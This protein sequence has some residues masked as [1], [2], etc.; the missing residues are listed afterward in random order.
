MENI[1]QLISQLEAAH[2]NISD[3]ARKL[4]LQILEMENQ[5]QRYDFIEREVRDRTLNDKN[6]RLRT[7]IIS[8]YRRMISHELG[9]VQETEQTRFE[10]I[11]RNAQMQMEG[12]LAYFYQCQYGE[13]VQQFVT[14]YNNYVAELNSNGR[15]FHPIQRE[16]WDK[17]TF[18][19]K[20][21]LFQHVTQ[22]ASLINF[23]KLLNRYRNSISHSGYEHRAN[24][25]AP[26]DDV[27]V[28]AR[29]KDVNAVLDALEKL[30]EYVEYNTI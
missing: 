14:A 27:S 23:I 30:R 10:N 26:N 20:Y 28:F 18:S 12:L 29:I 21:F 24:G 1:P 6:R 5:A 15:S 9:L 16:R 11:C 8:C 7:R 19:D 17:L 2:I 13:N 25:T 4:K 22:D 3:V